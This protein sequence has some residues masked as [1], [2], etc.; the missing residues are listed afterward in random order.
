MLLTCYLP[1]S[2]FPACAEG[3]QFHMSVPTLYAEK[4]PTSAALTRRA[5][6]LAPKEGMGGSRG[7]QSAAT[8]S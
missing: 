8:F 7:L 3:N 4:G 2:L 5:V 1:T 6:A